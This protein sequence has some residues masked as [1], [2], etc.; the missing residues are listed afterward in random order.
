MPLIQSEALTD[1]AEE[2]LNAVSEALTTEN[3][4]EYLAMVQLEQQDPSVVAEQFLTDEGVL[5]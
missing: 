2:A 4:T 3:L 1:E 5:G